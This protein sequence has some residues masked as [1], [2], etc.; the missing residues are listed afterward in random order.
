M[1]RH[2]GTLAVPGAG[3]TPV[4]WILGRFLPAC[5]GV[6]THGLPDFKP[7]DFTSLKRPRRPNEAVAAPASTGLEPDFLSP[8]F[9]LSADRLIGT[10]IDVAARQPR[11]TLAARFGDPAQLWFVSR[12]FWCNFPDLIVA[13]ALP[14][15][16][17][18]SHLL[19]YS[20]SVY[21]Y[22]DFGVNRRRMSG[23]L[24]AIDEAARK[25]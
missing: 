21:G 25:G 22:A 13:Q 6:G 5:A 12:S 23:W 19:L 14:E 2:R 24:A 10:V 3:L 4:A 1:P 18:R 15:G 7:L 17:K 8:T 20:R 11:T 9:S 16:P